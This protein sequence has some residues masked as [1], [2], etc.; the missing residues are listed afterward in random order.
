MATTHQHHQSLDQA[1]NRDNTH[2]DFSVTVGRD[3]WAGQVIDNVVGSESEQGDR[4]EDDPLSAVENKIRHNKRQFHAN[5]CL[6]LKNLPE[7]VREE[8]RCLSDLVL[9]FW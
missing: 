3:S 5:R 4:R 9:A 7:G 1:R 6:E 8:V 2:Q